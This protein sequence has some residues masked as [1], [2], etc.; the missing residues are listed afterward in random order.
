ME[1]D[2]EDDEMAPGM[3]NDTVNGK[4]RV[5]EDTP[6]V[7]SVLSGRSADNTVYIDAKPEIGIVSPHLKSNL[8]FKH[9]L[10]EISGVDSSGKIEIFRR[11]KEFC[12]KDEQDKINAIAGLLTPYLRGLFKNFNT[13]TPLFF[14]M[15]NR[16]RA[17][18]DYS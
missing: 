18:K 17:G 15:A 2:K 5:S 7:I 3:F 14:Y 4:S 1:D 10:Y 6:D 11:Y 9:T 8:G 13:R 12:F 16:E